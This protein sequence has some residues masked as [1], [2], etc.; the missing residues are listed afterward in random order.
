MFNSILTYNPVTTLP[1]LICMS[2]AV[3]LGIVI[4]LIYRT[5]GY[6]SS[7]FMLT[8]AVI[9]AVVQAVILVVN[10]NL[11]TAVAV[12]GA[13]SLV[14]FRSLAGSAK[15]ITFVFYA[16]AAGLICGMGYVLFA[17]I[18]VLVVGLLVIILSKLSILE[19]SSSTRQLKINIPENLDYSDMFDDLFEKY[20]K[21]VKLERVRTTNLG[22][23]FEL[24]YNIRLKDVKKEKSFIDDLRCRNGNLTI[25][26][27]ST[28]SPTDL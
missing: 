1:V 20:L 26:C 4:M 18:F 7:S 5:Q 28:H 11:G 15:E 16:M 23:M 12:A 14:R 19:A 2:A 8:L 10:G 9:P 25:M 21:Y 13:F 3:V 17:I 6:Y 27:Q 22:S 24:T